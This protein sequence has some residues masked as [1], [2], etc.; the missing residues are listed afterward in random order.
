MM[1]V[2]VWF[3]LKPDERNDH[4]LVTEVVAAP[5]DDGEAAAF[6]SIENTGSPDRLVGVESPVAEVALYTPGHAEG[7]PVPVG[8]STLAPD[9]AHIRMTA[10]S[11]TFVDGSLIP[12]TLTFAEA[13]QVAAKAVLVD[14]KA[15]GDAEEFGLFGFADICVVGE[16]E[17]APRI[18][19]AVTPEDDGWRVRVEAEEFTFS[20]DFVD[21]YHVPGMGH[22]HLYVGGMKIGRLYEPEAYIGA[23]PK[24]QHEIRVTL[25]TNDHRAYVVDDEP[26]TASATIEVD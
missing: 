17:P 4:I 19:L 18:A 23:L 26:V 6:M 9:S 5:T 16:G 3:A 24:G 8:K 21:L 12:L 22:G 14:P 2:L 7:P 1:A 11:E 15:K 25:N 10:S 20:K 13:G